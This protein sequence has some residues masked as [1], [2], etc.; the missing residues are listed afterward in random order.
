MRDGYALLPGWIGGAELDA[1]RA[2]ADALVAR[3][4]APACPRPNNTLLPLRWDDALVNL[5]VADRARVDALADATGAGDLRWISGYLSVKEPHTG[6]LDWHQDW[7]CWD[8]PV[9]FEDAAPQV[10]L[11]VYLSDTDERTGALRVRRGGPVTL[12]ARAG[13]AVVLD[14]RLEHGTHPNAAAARR[15]AVLLSFAPSWAMLPEDIRGHLIA[16]AAQPGDGE[17]ATRL[18]VARL[19]PRH[20]GPR[21]DLPLNRIPPSR[22]VAA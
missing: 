11:L 15:D 5:L 12:P 20:D 8:H 22:R 1:A 3:G 19:L 21:R 16:H 14:Y 13:D 17:P 18:P 2:A 7:W 6:A 4:A 10:A 9:S